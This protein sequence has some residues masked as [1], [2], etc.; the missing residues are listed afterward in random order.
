MGVT[1]YF[2]AQHLK[3]LFLFGETS[4]LSEEQRARSP[5]EKVK[6]SQGLL[7]QVTQVQGIGYFTQG[8]SVSNEDSN[9]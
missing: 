3:H 9:V 1:L 5:L 4:A 6:N 7:R 8:F 2:A